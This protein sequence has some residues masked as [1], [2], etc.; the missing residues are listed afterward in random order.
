MTLSFE[1]IRL[2]RQQDYLHL[3]RHCPEIASD[4]SFINIWAWGLE[5]GLEWAWED[6]LVWLRQRGPGPDVW[7]AP[8]GDWNAV[9]WARRLPEAMAA[10]DCFSRVPE[11]LARLWG[12]HVPSITAEEERAHWDYLY[13]IDELRELG[14]NRFHK[15]KNLVNQFQKKYDSRYLPFGKEMVEKAWTLQ[16][17]WCTWRD[18]ESSDTLSAE[19]RAI[20]TTL[21]SWDVLTGI[22]GGALLVDETIV[23]YTIAEAISP[24]TLLIHF[25]KANPDFKGAYQAINKLFLDHFDG[26]QRQVNREQDLGNE[27]LRKA[28]QSYHPIGFVKKYRV[29]HPDMA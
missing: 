9:D 13:D 10:A 21:D 22:T 24:D 3:L 19:N 6:D 2:D 20:E 5:H 16:T 11:P 27:G 4:Y 8:V 25:E 7:W 17:D 14:G 1:P 29:S 12:E 23:A 15:K 28:K 18:C 26:P